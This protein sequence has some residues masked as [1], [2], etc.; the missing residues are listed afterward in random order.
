[1]TDHVAKREWQDAASLTRLQV[2]PIPEK[3]TP[4]ESPKRTAPEHR[5]AHTERTPHIVTVAIEDYYN[6]FKGVID[7][8]N[9]SRFET[10]VEASTLRT[11]DLLDEFGIRATFFGVGWIANRIPDVFREVARRGHEVASKGYTQRAIAE[12]TPEEFR[13]DLAKAREALEAACGQRVV[14][15]RAP[16]WLGP[17]D[18]WALKVLAEEGYA[19]DSSIKP[20]FHWRSPPFTERFAH[21]KYFGERTLWEF[22][23]STVGVGRTLIPIGA[24]NYFRQLPDVV[25][26]S[27]IAH[28]DH[29]YPGAPFVMYFHTWEL[30]PE[31]P[32]ITAAPLLNRIRKYRNLHK[33]PEILRRYFHGHRFA[34]I[35][36]YLGLLEPRMPRIPAEAA[37]PI[38]VV[39]RA[40]LAP[41]V[42]D[43]INDED[44]ASIGIAT[45]QEPERIAPRE[46]VDELRQVRERVTL[47]VPC[48][49]EEHSLPYLA[50]TLRSVRDA[51]SR[52]YEIEAIFVDDNSSDRT[53]QVLDELFA[54]HP[55]VVRI[56]HE[57]NR[58]VAA[59]ILT[60]LRHAGTE[61]VCS[62]DCDCSYDP[63]DLANM[64]PLLRDDV[65]LVTA[66]PY[67][68]QGRVH[69]VP[70]WRLLLSKSLSRI[71]RIVLR[72][73]LHTY[74]S[75]FR[76]YRRSAII[77]IQPERGGFLGIAELLGKLA[78]SGAEI[79]EHP[80]TL[81]VR[82]L[83]H[84]K[85]KILQT[86]AGHLGLITSLAWQRVAQRA[87]VVPVVDRASAVTPA[88]TPTEMTNG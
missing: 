29:R 31:Q 49:N 81:E 2:L 34:C 47:V 6:N 33:V 46:R 40:D 83:G 19:F 48:Y 59:S 64:I 78:L 7:R 66:S 25:V 52:N 11:L 61:I 51:L 42:P 39:R 4:P 58:G 72:Q 28:W 86:I 65:A 82:V 9:W 43:E 71:Y 75:C 56:R 84:S 24:G 38:P 79:V 27:A 57:T 35:G 50:N 14:G 20:M 45:L 77:E 22:P 88:A 53:C 23:I 3:M 67:H 30:D 37:L 74:T 55:E 87:R 32:Q 69:H 76:V 62:I 16:G 10:R 85:M 18:M 70:T 12:M 1:M 80:A 54:G 13:D 5:V 8:A 36:D 41:T 26:Q 15:Y 17:E 68:P 63:H 21:S 73:P 60:G 44:L